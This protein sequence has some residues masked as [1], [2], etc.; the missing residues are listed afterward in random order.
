M[1]YLVVAQPIEQYKQKEKYCMPL[2]IAYVNGALRAAGLDVDGINMMFVDG[3]PFDALYNKI[4]EEKFDVVLCGGLSAEYP[5]L[6]KVF[7]IAK[8]ANP[9]VITI[10]GDR[11]S[12]V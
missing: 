4:I 12:V 10:G 2:G 7:D 6:K 9:N 1:R 8:K 5:M 3:D 11:K